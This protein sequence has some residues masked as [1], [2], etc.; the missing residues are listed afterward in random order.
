METLQ[1][2]AVM[3]FHAVIDFDDCNAEGRYFIQLKNKAVAAS[4]VLAKFGG[5]TDQ[6]VI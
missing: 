4:W 5:N 2:I 1:V 3:I 6:A